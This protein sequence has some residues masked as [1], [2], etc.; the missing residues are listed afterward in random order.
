MPTFGIWGGLA[1]CTGVNRRGGRP[2]PCPSSTE[3]GACCP[4]L[5]SCPPCFF[6]MRRGMGPCG[7]FNANE[8]TGVCVCVCVRASVCAAWFIAH[9]HTRT[10]TH[11]STG[12]SSN[13]STSTR[14]KAFSR[15]APLSD[16]A[17]QAAECWG[18]AQ[19]KMLRQR[20]VKTMLGHAACA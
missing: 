17:W 8:S 9:A 1:A 14:P 3:S 7:P 20:C 6:G 11:T 12:T 4:R 2:P 5:G 10:Y 16:R 18:S 13:T 19:T 15:A